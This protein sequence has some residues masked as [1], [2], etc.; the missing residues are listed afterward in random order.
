[1]IRYLLAFSL[2]AHA[3]AFEVIETKNATQDVVVA[4]KADASPLQSQLQSL[5]KAG[6]GTLFLKAGRYELLEP[7][8]IPQGTCLR[9]DGQDTILVVKHKLGP[10]VNMSSSSALRGV[11]LWWP[12]Q[13]ADQIIEYPAGIAAPGATTFQI[14]DVTLINAYDGLR[15]GPESNSL[16]LVRRLRGTCLKRGMFEDKCKGVPR[17]QHLS[18]SPRY[19][20]QS[21]L[22]G[23]PAKDGPHRAWM[24]QNGT[25]IEWADADA[26]NVLDA[27]IEGYRYGMAFIKARVA[28]S[29]GDLVGVR[30]RDCGTAVEV[31]SLQGSVRFTDCD[32]TGTQHGVH[33]AESFGSPT[34]HLLMS[35]CRLSSI[36]DDAAARSDGLIHMVGG[37]VSGV[38]RMN[39]STGS[40]VGVKMAGDAEPE[41]FSIL[42]PPHSIS[43]DPPLTTKPARDE[44]FVVTDKSGIQAA[45]DAAGTKG[46]G[47]VFLPAGAYSITKSLRVPSGVEL[48]GPLDFWQRQAGRRVGHLGAVLHIEGDATVELSPQSGVRG[49]TFYYPQQSFKTP[50][51]YPYAIRGLGSD[52]YVISTFLV[53]PHAGIDFAT[54]RCDRFMTDMVLMNP[55]SRGLAIGSGST[56]G[57]IQNTHMNS[58]LW[59]HGFWENGPPNMAHRDGIAFDEHISRQLV[60]YDFDGCSQMRLFS[61]FTH[62]ARHLYRLKDAELD[63]TLAGAESTVEAVVAESLGPR[64]VNLVNFHVL[65]TKGHHRVPFTLKSSLKPDAMIRGWN[66]LTFGFPTVLAEVHGGQLLFELLWDFNSRTASRIRT[67]GEGRVGLT[68]CIARNPIVLEG[69]H[70]S[71]IACRFDSLIGSASDR[72]APRTA[73]VLLEHPPAEHGLCLQS[74]TTYSPQICNPTQLDVLLPARVAKTGEMLFDLTDSTLHPTQLI[75]NWHDSAPQGRT[76]VI[77]A[78]GKTLS[79][80]TTAG[81][82]TWKAESIPLKASPKQIRL[83]F[84]NNAAI[85]ISQIE[86]RQP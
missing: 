40:F 52:V 65:P 70:I 62:G 32:F 23:A 67:S 84:E 79:T 12:E 75:V 58:A 11:A 73:L 55:I 54:H 82:R 3:A 85:A 80:L 33:L 29:T 16:C 46:G 71:A 38:V 8:T 30:I 17:F 37:S 18:F 50:K 22:P 2:T 26:F 76:F 5:A 63:V 43:L 27:E 57:L 34:M 1:M 21:G 10:A 19:W 83:R 72:H 61:C 39:H 24:L 36:Q 68:G 44:L 59:A 69:G 25:G 28:A 4:V 66:T 48:R 56:G 45:L 74:E 41:H 86:L 42:S 20:E 15:F 47:I 14:E 35:H 13:R 6:G 78:D 9:G 31:Q 53:N 7:L 64:G 77:E 81:T 51:V 60:A 49:L